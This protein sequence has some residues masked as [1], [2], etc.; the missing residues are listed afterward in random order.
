MTPTAARPLRRDA[1]RNR[2]RVLAAA[3]EL[4]AERGLEVTLDD[5]ARRAGLGVGTVYRRFPSREALIEALFSEQLDALV[6]LAGECLRE[7]NSWDGLVRFLEDF[8]CRHGGDRAMRELLFTGAAQRPDFARIHAELVPAA[9][10]LVARAQ[11][12]GHLRPDLRGT[13]LPQIELMISS[14]AECTRGVDPE[15]WRRYL[16][17]LLDGLRAT[18]RGPSPLP[19]PA[20]SHEQTEQA[21]HRR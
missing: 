19:A 6:T 16:T 13:D 11:R 12:D 15:V 4:F 8:A 10:E 5:V 3:R 21:L 1:E 17:L 2:Q 14:V 20:L 18:P 7:Q 9:D